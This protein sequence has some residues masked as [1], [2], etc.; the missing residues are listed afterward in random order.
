MAL[1]LEIQARLMLHGLQHM[2]ICP[3]T[4]QNLQVCC[5]VS[6]C[7]NG[8]SYCGRRQTKDEIE[9]KLQIQRLNRPF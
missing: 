9:P 3:E 4:C 6:E 1:D 7:V 2:M 8:V 5:L